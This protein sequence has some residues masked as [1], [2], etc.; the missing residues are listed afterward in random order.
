M[1][2]KTDRDIIISFI[3]LYAFHLCHISVVF[4]VNAHIINVWI[5][6]CFHFFSFVRWLESSDFIV[7]W[8]T[9]SKYVI[10]HYLSILI[11]MLLEGKNKHFFVIFFFNKS[12]I[13]FFCWNG[14]MFV[15]LKMLEL[16]RYTY[17]N[18]FFWRNIHSFNEKEKYCFTNQNQ[19]KWSVQSWDIKAKN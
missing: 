1:Q 3:I 17:S 5:I 10:D 8:W 19:L 9:Q 4:N 7:V 11:W 14:S 6:L 2:A 15:P 13:H 12:L 16:W 18:C